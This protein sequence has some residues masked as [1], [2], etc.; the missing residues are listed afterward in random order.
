M[1]KK[2]RNWGEE[3]PQY[4]E[5]PEVPRPRAK[6]DRRR[7]CRGREGIE[8]I[9]ALTCDRQWGNGP[10]SWGLSYYQG[11]H[12]AWRCQHRRRCTVCHKVL[13][14]TIK[15]EECPSLRP[16]PVSPYSC[17]RCG[18]LQDKHPQAWGWGHPCTQCGCRSFWW[19]EKV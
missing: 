11:L 3:K 6:K 8:H 1:S 4:V 7:W 14:Y 10:C 15:T 5:P 12:L 18:H 17:S 16:K 19:E 9:P 2:L 13:D